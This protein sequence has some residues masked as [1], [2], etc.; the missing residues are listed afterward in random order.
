M[1]LY[2][3][4]IATAAIKARKTW[5]DIHGCGAKAWIIYE[6]GCVAYA[7]SSPIINVGRFSGRLLTQMGGSQSLTI[8][9]AKQVSGGAGDPGSSWHV[10]VFVGAATGTFQLS[11]EA[12]GK[13]VRR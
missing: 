8:V 3:N 4:A 11:I 7:A 1:Q 12:K 10:R 13:I 5:L 6:F 9:T 2:T